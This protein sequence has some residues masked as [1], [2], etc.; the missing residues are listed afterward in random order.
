MVAFLVFSHMTNEEHIDFWL[1][2]SDV[3]L[4]TAQ[5]MFISKFYDWSLF[6]AHLALEKL[7][8][9]IWIKENNEFI[10]PK[11]HNLMRLAEASNL[12]LSEEQI[13]FLRMVN[14]FNIEARY[15]EIKSSFHKLATENFTKLQLNKISEFHLWLKSQI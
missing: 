15:Q 9:A 3:D 10:P 14:Q 7:L 11:T 1:N 12:K 2:S 5:R 6:V 4:K 8:K 13:E